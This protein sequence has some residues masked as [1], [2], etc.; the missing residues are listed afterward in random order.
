MENAN[1]DQR[2]IG[3]SDIDAAAQ[4]T[5]KNIKGYRPEEQVKAVNQF[6][7][8]EAQKEHEKA[9]KD[10]P[11]YAARSHGNEPHPGAL[12]DKELKRVDEETV[13]KMD[14]RKRNA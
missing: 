14:E 11:T 13:R 8:E 4:H 6:R 9:L 12:V 7:S 10:D 1:D 2:H 5:G 3:K